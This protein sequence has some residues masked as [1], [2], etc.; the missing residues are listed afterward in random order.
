[1]VDIYGERRIFWRIILNKH[2]LY[3]VQLITFDWTA[4]EWMCVTPFGE[5]NARTT[6]NILIN[7]STLKYMKNNLL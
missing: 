2:T 5:D 1:M 6:D 7:Q 3:I 4:R